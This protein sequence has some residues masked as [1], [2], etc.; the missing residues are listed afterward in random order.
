[1]KPIKKAGI[2]IGATIGGV[3]GGA[4]SVVGHVTKIKFLDD[5]GNSI[6]DSTILTGEITGEAASGVMHLAAGGAEALGEF[7]EVEKA[8]SR[9]KRRH[10]KAAKRDLKDAGGAVLGNAFTNVKIVAKTSGGIAKG[11]KEGDKAKVLKGVKTLGKMAT[12]GAITVGAIK[13]DPEED[14][15]KKADAAQGANAPKGAGM[16][17]ETDA[18]KE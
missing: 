9:K 1:M 8:N 6:V 14:A 2:I 15:P 3:V 16:P 11:I 13:I 12:I 5:L 4:V 17:A 7:M 18:R 10:L